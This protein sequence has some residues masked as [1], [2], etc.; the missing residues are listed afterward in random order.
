MEKKKNII[1]LGSTGS[2][3]RSALEV[4]ESNSDKFSVKYLST[5]TRVDLLL[6]QAKKFNP[7]GIII[8]D[9]EA[10]REV[11]S[12]NLPYEVYSKNELLEL[13]VREDIDIVIAAMVGFA[14][15]E[16]T[17]EAIKSGKKI[18]LA[19]KETL[20]VAG[21]IITKIARENNSEIIPIDSEHS[22]IL[23]CIVGENKSQI[24]K[25]ILTASGGPFLNRDYKDFDS[26]T[27]EEA[28]QHP[29]WKMGNKITID[30]ATMMNKGLEV[31]EAHWLFGMSKDQIEVIIHPQSIIHSMVEFVDGSIKAQL[32]VPDMKIPIQYALSYPERFPVSY[33]TMDFVKH[34]TLTFLE[35][36]F[37]KF[38]CLE[39]AYKSLELGGN[40]PVILNAANEVAVQKFLNNEIRFTQIPEIIEQA[41]EKFGVSKEPGLDEIFEWDFKVREYLQQSNKVNYGIF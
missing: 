38:K 34:S 36:D 6:E 40:Y 30:S 13:I 7:R 8:T 37:R 12:Y 22:A 16:S 2:I 19:N 26:I 5:N 32:G 33:S 39:L 27:I 41:L 31:I 4:I 9:D 3:G 28:L 24:R 20:V 17:L 35:P 21:H 18:A 11:K 25:I 23:Q 29:N 15:L 14:G 1:I 10:Y